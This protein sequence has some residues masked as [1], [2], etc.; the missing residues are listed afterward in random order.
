MYGGGGGQRASRPCWRFYP[1]NNRE[2]WK[3]FKQGHVMTKFGYQKSHSCCRW[4]EGTKARWEG[5]GSVQAQGST[6][7]WRT[8]GQARG[9]QVLGPITRQ[10]IS[11]LFKLSR[12]P[13]VCLSRA[14]DPGGCGC[15]RP[16]KEVQTLH[17]HHTPLRPSVE[18]NNKK[19]VH[20][21]FYSFHFSHN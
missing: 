6:L 3:G 8:C 1:G 21:F 7:L 5:I 10:S 2:P 19:L 9:L 11:Q 13:H 16:R 12:R 15:R 20:C 4:S 17:E 14:T 18:S